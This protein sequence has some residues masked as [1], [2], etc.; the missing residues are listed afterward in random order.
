MFQLVLIIMYFSF[1]FKSLDQDSNGLLTYDEIRNTPVETWKD[2]CRRAD[3]PHG[4]TKY[5]ESCYGF[6]A[7][8]GD[9]S[10]TLSLLAYPA[11]M[12]FLC[13]AIGLDAV[14]VF[15]ERKRHNYHNK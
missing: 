15:A 13:H 10:N 14:R 11:F 7:G 9:V 4:P 1:S 12:C 3:Y 5:I 8:N 2:V 6:S